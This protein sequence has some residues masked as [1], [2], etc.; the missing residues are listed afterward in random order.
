MK[1]FDR[2]IDDAREALRDLFWV[3]L[4]MSAFGSR[5]WA[6]GALG[7]WGARFAMV[8]IKDRRHERL[9]GEAGR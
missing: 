7:A 9:A 6:A 2:R 4:G 5:W 3:L 1:N 8:V